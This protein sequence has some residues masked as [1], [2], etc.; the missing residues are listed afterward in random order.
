MRLGTVVGDEALQAADRDR[1]PASEG[2]GAS[3]LALNALVA[4]TAADAGEEARLAEHVVSLVE[5]PVPERS[6]EARDV[7]VGGTSLHAGWVRAIE[8]AGG[9]SER[10]RPAL[11][12]RADL[13]AVTGKRFWP[14]RERVAP[15]GAHEWAGDRSVSYTHL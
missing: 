5:V 9:L 4:D 13:L 2:P 11:E 7:D 8:A 6:D 10:F 1:L 3:T 12:A 15:S 14:E